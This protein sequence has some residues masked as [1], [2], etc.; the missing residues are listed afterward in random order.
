MKDWKYDVQAGAGDGGGGLDGLNVGGAGLEGG[1]RR[2]GTWL[3]AGQHPP[4]ALLDADR[5]RLVPRAVEVLEDRDGGRNRDLVLARPAAINNA[6]AEHLHDG[7]AY[8]MN[9]TS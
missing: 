6:H 7:S 9:R 3:P 4:A 2:K 5:D 1:G 8:R